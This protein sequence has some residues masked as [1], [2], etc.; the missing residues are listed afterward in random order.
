MR[1]TQVVTGLL[2]ALKPFGF[3][4]KA[5]DKFYAGIP[6]I[7]GCAQG[8]FVALEVK[9]DNNEATP[10][11]KHHLNCIEKCGGISEVVTYLNLKRIYRIQDAELSRQGVVEWL[12]KRLALNTS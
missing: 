3:F 4:W 6:D 11:Q 2:R 9:I 8:R 10:L 7:I 1:E 5:S 12:L